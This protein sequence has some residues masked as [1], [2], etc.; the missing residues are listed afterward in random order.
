MSDQSNTL[1][2]SDRQEFAFRL[3]LE[4]VDGE[5]AER[6]GLAETPARAAAA[7]REKTSGYRVDTENL[8]KTFDTE[9]NSVRGMVVVRDIEIESMC[10]HHLERIWGYAHIGYVPN[11]RVLGLSKFHRVVD[12]L[13]RRLVVQERLTASIADTISRL[14][15]PQGVGVVIEA[16]HACMEARG[17]KRRGSV[18]MTSELRGCF[19]SD[20]TTRAEFLSL[21]RT[22][23]T[24]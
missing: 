20:A 7:W 22:T 12:A 1:H 3:L 10:E 17:I 8:F 5:I 9:L 24:F 21:A 11:S 4:T 14:L 18:T 13:A 2:R 16:R 19:Y 23:N 6:P 15:V